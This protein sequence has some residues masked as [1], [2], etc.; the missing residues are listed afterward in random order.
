MD[1]RYRAPQTT[2]RMQLAAAVLVDS[3]TQEQRAEARYPFADE[4]SRTDWDFIPKSGRLGLPLWR[5]D[6]RQRV[7]AHQLLASGVALPTYA[8]VV[9][10]MANEGVLRE[11]Q[12]DFLGLGAGEFRDPEGYCFSFFGKPNFEETWGWRVVGHHVSLTFTIVGGEYLAPTPLLLG[13][14][15]AAFGTF[16]PLADDEELGFRLLQALDAAQLRQAL[17]HEVA[18][19]DVVT[20]V[21]ARIGAEERPDEREVGLPDYRI[22]DHD[23]EQLRYVRDEPRGIG[24][25]ALTAPQREHLGRLIGGYLDRVPAEVAERHRALLDGGG[26]DRFFFAWAGSAERG[27]PHYYRIQGPSFL[28]EFEN[29]QQGGNHIHTVWRDPANDFGYD[30]LRQHHE[31]EHGAAERPLRLRRLTSSRPD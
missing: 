23:R 11:L 17:I 14:E 24:A 10:I 22:T 21:V 29:V 19:P 31:E 8:K 27:N 20:R 2:R 4:A 28:V 5:M 15:P 7:L 30:L 25:A 1:E 13:A 16:A 9:A 6:R 18:P 12:K 26:L 3:F